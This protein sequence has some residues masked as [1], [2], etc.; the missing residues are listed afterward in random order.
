MTLKEFDFT[1]NLSCGSLFFIQSYKWEITHK[2]DIIDKLKIEINLKLNLII[3]RSPNV[4]C[5]GPM[6]DPK[7]T[8]IWWSASCARTSW[9]PTPWGRSASGRCAWPTARRTASCLPKRLRPRLRGQCTS[10]TSRRGPTMACRSTLSRS[11][12]SCGTRP[13][14]TPLMPDRL[15]FI[16]GNSSCFQHIVKHYSVRRLTGSRIIE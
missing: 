1:N 12:P 15:L 2:E 10:T 4:T 8:A 14:P 7:R 9:P 13:R 6:P 11:S 16:A 5:T 3:F